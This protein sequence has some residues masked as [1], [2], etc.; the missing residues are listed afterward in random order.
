MPRRTVPPDG[1]EKDKENEEDD[2]SVHSE[3]DIQP[4]VPRRSSSRQ[5]HVR[6]ECAP[7]VPD[8]TLVTPVPPPSSSHEPPPGRSKTPSPPTPYQCD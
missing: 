5:R 4:L 8:L 3:R 2:E 7:P 6:P 1:E